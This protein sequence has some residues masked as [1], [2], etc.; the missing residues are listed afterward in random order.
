MLYCIAVDISR[1]TVKLLSEELKCVKD[2]YVFGVALGI[3][4]SELDCI[5]SRKPFA[6][7]RW[8]A[9][10]SRCTVYG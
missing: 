1:L 5:K 7:I 3:P 9:G 2:W 8:R 4:V 6:L 10:R